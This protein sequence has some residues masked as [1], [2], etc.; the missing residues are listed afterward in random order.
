M[1]QRS[2]IGICKPDGADGFLYLLPPGLWSLKPSA[3]RS[4]GV[5]WTPDLD[6]AWVL[7]DA[8]HAGECRDGICRRRESPGDDCAQLVYFTITEIRKLGIT[9]QDISVEALI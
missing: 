9:G 8:E 7:R 4:I 1:T 3:E 5:E 2:A 6:E